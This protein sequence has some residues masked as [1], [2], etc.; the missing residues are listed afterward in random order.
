MVETYFVFS[1]MESI[2]HAC[3]HQLLPSGESDNT[4]GHVYL[5]GYMWHFNVNY[6][7]WVCVFTICSRVR[8]IWG[9]GVPGENL[10]E[11]D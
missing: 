3:K 2:N 5:N 10:T 8:N 7:F 1:Y 9:C 11:W 6:D 4:S